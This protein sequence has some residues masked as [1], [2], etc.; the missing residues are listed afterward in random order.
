MT[1]KPCCRPR[2]KDTVLVAVLGVVLHL[3]QVLLLTPEAPGVVLELWQRVAV[4]ALQ[5]VVDHLRLPQPLQLHVLLRRV[6]T[7]I[8]FS[9]QKTTHQLA[10]S[11]CEGEKTHT[12][13]QPVEPIT[14]H[15]INEFFFKKSIFHHCHLRLNFLYLC[16]SHAS[17]AVI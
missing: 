14:I 16:A 9:R 13:K 6:K 15:L 12:S 2:W 4:T 1:Q 5:S 7:G 3:L 8:F 11:A 17:A 10:G